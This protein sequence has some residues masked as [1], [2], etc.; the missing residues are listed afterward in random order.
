M[1]TR[2][3]MQKCIKQILSFAGK[4]F[5][6]EKYLIK[7]HFWHSDRYDLQKKVNCQLRY[8]VYQCNSDVLYKHLYSQQAYLLKLI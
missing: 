5:I 1:Q 3:T 4:V 8:C 7:F 2:Q 6:L